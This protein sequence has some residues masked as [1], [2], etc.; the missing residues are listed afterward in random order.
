[1]NEQEWLEKLQKEG[2]KHS[3]VVTME[4]GSTAEHTHDEPTI[5]VILNGELT[6]K[7]SKGEKIYHEGDYIEFP[8]GTTHSAVF[9][10]EGLTMI[11]GTK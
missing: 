4:P 7:D 5:H 9:G 6:I 8:A 2:V 1:M 10:P 11:V 3:T